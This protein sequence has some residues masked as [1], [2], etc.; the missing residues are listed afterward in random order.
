MRFLKNQN[1][2][3]KNSLQSSVTVDKD[4]IQQFNSYTI[5]Q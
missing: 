3:L 4:S 2:N 5:Q 1:T